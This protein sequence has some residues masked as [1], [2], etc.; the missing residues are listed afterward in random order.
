MKHQY[1]GDITDY[2]NYSLLRTLG[3]AD[4]ACRTALAW[5]LTPDDTRGDGRHT[6]YLD[7]P[8]R[9]RRYDPPLFD[10]LRDA[11]QHPE[12]RLGVDALAS[13]APELMPNTVFFDDIL[14][15][16]AYEREAYF[17]RLLTTAKDADLIYFDPDNGFEVASKPYG[18]TG[19][20]KYLYFRELAPFCH[21]RA[22]LM[23]IQFF[24]R[25]AR[26][27]YLKSQSERIRSALG[28]KSLYAAWNSKVAFW[29]MPGRGQS[30]RV[31]QAL[32][33]YGTTCHDWIKISEL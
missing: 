22:T 24:P 26:E 8:E 4:P 5:M 3:G 19:A 27:S 32:K 25:C 14:G 23:T 33:L 10:H 11:V 1:Y 9:W 12:G 7:D 29:I 16:R 20:H 21:G 30:R 18:R 2:F 6:K 13:A 17:Q 31:Q 15:D 28:I